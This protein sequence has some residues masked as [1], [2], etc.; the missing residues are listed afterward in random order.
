MSGQVWHF[1]E[2]HPQEAAITR[3][4]SIAPYTPL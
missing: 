1:A 3:E 2:K 4:F